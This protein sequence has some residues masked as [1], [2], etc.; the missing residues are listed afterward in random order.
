MASYQDR[1]LKAETVT[2][3]PICD[4]ETIEEGKNGFCLC[5]V[6]SWVKGHK[7]ITIK[8]RA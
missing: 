5:L 6:H 3:C 8:G 2:L 1:S 7:T 4:R